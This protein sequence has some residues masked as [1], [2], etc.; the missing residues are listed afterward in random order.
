VSDD[1]R[2]TVRL[3]AGGS[4]IECFSIQHFF[5]LTA[6]LIPISQRNDCASVKPRNPLENN[7]TLE[8]V[9]QQDEENEITKCFSFLILFVGLLNW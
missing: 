4:K 6:H 1:G 7:Y 5:L 2:M 8:G 3:C 9:Q